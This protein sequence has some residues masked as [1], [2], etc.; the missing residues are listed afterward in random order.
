MRS[1]RCRD[2]KTRLAESSLAFWSLSNCSRSSASF[3]FLSVRL[4]IHLPL[5]GFGQGDLNL[6]LIAPF[7]DGQN[8]AR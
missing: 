2:E 8:L 7:L 3:C 4:V 6:G 5:P 1:N